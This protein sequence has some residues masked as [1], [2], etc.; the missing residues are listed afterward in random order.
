M[1]MI[2]SPEKIGL[3]ME[4]DHDHQPE[5][6]AHFF[7]Q[8][9]L[10]ITEGYKRAGKPKIEVFRP[11]VH[12]D[13]LCHGDEHLLAVVTDAT[14]FSSMQKVPIF[15]TADIKSLANFIVKYFDLI[16]MKKEPIGKAAS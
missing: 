6:L 16:P 14:E 2:S 11:Q 5:E 1:A 9:D 13:I 4:V 10:I 15:G 7:T 12:G 3:V 8:M